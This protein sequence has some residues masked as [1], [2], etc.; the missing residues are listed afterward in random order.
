MLKNKIIY[1]SFLDLRF[2]VSKATGSYIWDEN[3]KKYI[4]FTSGWNTMNLGWNDK[5]IAEA[6]KHQ[7]KRNVHAPMWTSDQIQ[8]DYANLLTKYLPKGL[9]AIGRTTGGMES[10]LEA[11]KLARVYT[12]RK[13]ILG[14]IESWHGQLIENMY[15]S[16]LLEWM[17]HLSDKRDDLLHIPFPQTYRTDKSE[18]QLLTELETS[19]EN[20]LHNRDVAAV[21]T[22]CGILTG[23]G[24]AYSAPKGFLQL[25][26]KMTA[27]YGTLLIL[28]EV[29]SGFSR[30]GKLFGME[31][32]N[33]E[34]DMVTFAKG[35]TNGASP[36]GA[37][38]TT[39]KI[40]QSFKE[41][42]LQS[43]FGW[44]PLSCAAAKKTLEIHVKKELWKKAADDGQ[45]LIKILRDELSSLPFVGEIRGKGMLIGID[46]VKNKKTKEKNTELVEKTVKKAW[47]KR[48]HIVC[49]HESVIQLM[50][51]LTIER[52]LLDK[53][54]EIFIDV[55]KSFE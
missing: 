7:L 50:P 28:D 48:L 32:E 13:K 5:E 14:F 22:E 20:I 34:P 29:G 2:Q 19:L 37:M 31:F 49:D 47:E 21:I 38:V 1:T 8:Y 40:T 51:P 44:L 16:Y 27:K 52:N 33:V 54:I 53:G 39:E 36:M 10:N 55:V 9:K 25:I 15:M 26:R 11:M 18:L 6:I 46:L 30:L 23:W 24:S 45:Y 3:G 17:P 35:I 41:A 4:D 43:T 12:G 42:N